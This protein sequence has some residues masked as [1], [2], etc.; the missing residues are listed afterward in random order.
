[1]TGAPACRVIRTSATY[2]GKQGLSYGVGISAESA[3]SRALCLHLVTIPPGG[4]A[5]AHLHERHETAIYV[6]TGS[7]EVW[8][9]DGLQECLT[10]RAGDFLYIPA[11]APHLPTNP[12]PTEPS[13]KYPSRSGPRWASDALRLPKTPRGTGS[14][15]KF[16]IPKM[17]LMAE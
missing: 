16:Q 8:C 9:G 13:M 2:Q 5:K 17:P 3:G 12:S 10:I 6:L 4:R 14:P 7:A 11:G 15:V 1:M